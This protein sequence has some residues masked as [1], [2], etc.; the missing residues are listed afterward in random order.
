MRS[1]G[2]SFT[3]RKLPVWSFNR[4]KGISGHWQLGTSSYGVVCHRIPTYLF[5]LKLQFITSIFSETCPNLKKL[6]SGFHVSLIDTSTHWLHFTWLVNYWWPSLQLL[7]CH[8]SLYVTTVCR[9]FLI[10]TIFNCTLIYVNVMQMFFRTIQ[11][12]T[13]AW[14]HL[15]IHLGRQLRWGKDFM[16]L[17]HTWNSKYVYNVLISC[18][19]LYWHILTICLQVSEDSQDTKFH[20]YLQTCFAKRFH[21]Q[22]KCLNWSSNP[23]ISYS[24]PFCIKR[25]LLWLNGVLTAGFCQDVGCNCFV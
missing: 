6:I 5:H 8:H 14:T 22:A 1:D 9:T 24:A 11:V 4:N 23:S 16:D 7:A 10:I 12:F 18:E 25:P 15:Q 20:A 21:S 19:N 3:S 17:F 2:H 13:L